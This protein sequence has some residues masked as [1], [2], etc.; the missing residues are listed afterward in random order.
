MPHTKS[1]RYRADSDKVG[2]R[3]TA[4]SLADA[5]E[6]IKDC[7]KTKFDQS[8]DLCMH[9]GIDAKQAD[10]ALRGS[11]SLPHGVGKSKR[12]VAFCRDE[13]VEDVKSAGAI[14]AGGEDLVAKVEG[15]WM[16][17]DVAIASPDMMRVVSKLGRTLG[18][19][20]LM[21]SPKSG[22]VTPDITTAVKEYAAGKI[23]FRNDE[24]GNVHAAIGKLSFENNQLVENAQTMIDT[25]TKMKPAAVKGIFVKRITLSGTMTPGVKVAE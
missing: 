22:T 4:C 11:L 13:V 15:G 17:F 16:D 21:P 12:V 24:Y 20:G 14:E 5:V 25:I 2:D 3:D 18:P 19:K 9:L 1:K 10:Q 23:E 7:K 6:K 8:V